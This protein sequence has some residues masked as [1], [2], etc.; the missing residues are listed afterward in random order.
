MQ[1]VRTIAKAYAY[2]KEQDPETALTKHAFHSF[3]NS[4]LIPRFNVGSK[5]LVRLDDV[6]KFL[7]DGIPVVQPEIGIRRIK[8]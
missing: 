3:V 6:D 8:G 4:G 5:T 2:I 7:E 1:R